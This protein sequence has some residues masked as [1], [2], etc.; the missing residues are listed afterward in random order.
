ME[1]NKQIKPLIV[2]LEYLAR[3][4]YHVQSTLMHP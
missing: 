3:L 4:Q 2:F 1:E